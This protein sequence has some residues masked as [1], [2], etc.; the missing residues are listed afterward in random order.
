MTVGGA[1]LTDKQRDD[2]DY[3]TKLILQQTLLR[4]RSLEELEGQLVARENK[5]S[6]GGVFSGFFVDVK[7]ESRLKIARSHRQAVLWFLNDRLKEVS[8]KHSAQQEIRLSRQSEKSKSK[9]HNI[10]DDSLSRSNKPSL[11]AKLDS[12]R[13][14]NN[15]VDSAAA[16][17][18]IPEVLRNLT[19]TQLAQLETE[20]SAL[21][22]ELDASLSKAQAAEKSLY[23]ISSIQTQLAQHLSTQTEKIEHLMAD[24]EQVQ[25]DI[26]GANKQLESA[27]T[28]NKKASKIIIY[29]S[30]GFA[31]LLLFYDAITG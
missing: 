23:E 1:P 11:T 27:K 25:D 19:E 7:E 28:R 24:A 15:Y 14:N 22:D 5:G 4:I 26:E 3:E 17:E 9:I 31:G 29:T 8:S 30:L 6:G 20:N 13:K 2:I 10:G 21:L 16:Q 18:E 12:K